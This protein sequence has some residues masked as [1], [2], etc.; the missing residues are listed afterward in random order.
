MDE[1]QTR[2]IQ[3]SWTRIESS[4]DAMAAA[5]YDRLF[6]LD[7]R[8]RDLFAATEMESQSTKFLAMLAELV[9]LAQDP[10]QFEEALRS[11]GRRHAGY[12][13]VPSQYA[14]VG[15]ALLWA[16]ERCAGPEDLDQETR[17]AWAEAY[18]RMAFIMQ[19]AR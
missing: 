16:I 9:R 14:T 4:R 10:D 2:L 7:P 8:I 17:E 5:F 1:R 18:T 19:R 3:Q 6:E 12:G 11:S 13:V 15:E